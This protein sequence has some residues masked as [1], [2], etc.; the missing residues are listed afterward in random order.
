MGPSPPRDRRLAEALGVSASK[1]SRAAATRS[2]APRCGIAGNI[3]QQQGSSQGIPVRPS[4]RA[5]LERP[6]S[7]DP[8]S[9]ESLRA[10]AH[11]LE[12]DHLLPPER[13]DLEVAHLGHGT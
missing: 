4:T 10:L 11:V 8:G 6:L 7:L 13:P 9:L 5:Q 1:A 3:H 2:M 12:P